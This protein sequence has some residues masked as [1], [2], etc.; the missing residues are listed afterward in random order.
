[1]DAVLTVEIDKSGQKVGGQN[2]FN[3]RYGEISGEKYWDKDGSGTISAGDPLLKGWTI[4]LYEDTDGDGTFDP[5][6]DKWLKQTT[7]DA[8]G[9]YAFTKL[10]PGKY[11]VVED[12]DGPDGNWT[13]VG[14][15]WQAVHIDSSGKTVD[16]DFLNELE[17]CFEG[18]TPGFWRQ[19]Q[20]WKKVTLDPD[21]ADQAGDPFHGFANFRDIIPHLSFGAVF[22]VGDGTGA[23]DVTWK[24]GK[25]TVGFDVDKTTLLDALTIQGGGNVGAFLRHASAAILNA[26]AEEVDYAI[27]HEELIALVQ[28]AFGDL[29]KMTALKGILEDLNELGLEGSKGYQCPILDADYK[30]I[31]YVGELIA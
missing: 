1:S 15:W 22:K 31:G 29:A 26:C 21:C 25:T 3:A 23:W 19:T 18:L 2:F 17:V 27:P 30:V 13:P 14:D 12:K 28:D 8:S 9:S 6:V 7:T 20:N 10:L 24:V 11:I 16:V 5:N 4:H